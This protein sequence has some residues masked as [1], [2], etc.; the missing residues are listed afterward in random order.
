[1]TINEPNLQAHVEN[2]AWT[3]RV[4]G[5]REHSDACAYIEAQFR[6]FGYEPR[7]VPGARDGG[8]N[9]HANLGNQHKALFIIGAHY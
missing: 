1:M 9:V 7:R 8:V 5:S 2:L 6:L 4:P 3:P